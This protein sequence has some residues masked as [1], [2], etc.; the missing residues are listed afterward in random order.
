MK[1]AFVVALVL[2]SSAVLAQAPAPKSAD[3]TPQSAAPQAA[4]TPTE[5][6]SQIAKMQAL[7]TQMNK[8]MGDLQKT[9]DPA[10]RQ[11]LMQ[12]HWATMQ[13]AMTTG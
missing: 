11:K 8:Q 12:E 6:D 7:M 5:V 2:A 4:P 3:Q 9:Q 1:S 13:S 10:E